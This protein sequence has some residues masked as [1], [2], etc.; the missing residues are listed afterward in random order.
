MTSALS[1]TIAVTGILPTTATLPKARVQVLASGPLA[2]A[3]SAY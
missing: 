3:L 1:P 2:G